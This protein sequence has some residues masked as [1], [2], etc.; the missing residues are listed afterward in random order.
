VPLEGNKLLSIIDIIFSKAVRKPR[1][2][3]MPGPEFNFA[4]MLFAYS[5]KL[6][7]I[8]MGSQFVALLI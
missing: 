8:L 3:A 6:I 2:V 7:D 5:I 4:I 1:A